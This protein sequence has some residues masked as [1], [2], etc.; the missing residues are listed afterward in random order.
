ML[1]KLRNKKTAKKV[2]IILAV[3]I[4]PAF[5]LWGSGSVLRGKDKTEAAYTG[6]VYGRL[7]PYLEY[8]DAL[9]ATRNQAVIQFGENLEQIEK[10]L[11]IESQAWERIILLAEAKKRK[12]GSTDKEVVELIEGY[13][14]FQRKGRFDNRAYQETLRYVF[15]AQARVFEEQMRQNIVL[16]KLYKQLTDGIK[17]GDE[18]LRAE[19]ERANEELSL[20]YIAALPS[21]FVK[22]VA[23]L[24]NELKDYFVNNELQFKQP[25]SFNV[26]YVSAPSR[27]EIQ[28]LLKGTASNLKETG[29]FSETSSIPGI[30][31]SPQ[32]LSLISKAKPGEYTEA[33]QIDKDYYLFRVK[34]R[35]E[36]Y[37]PEFDKIKDK[38]KEVFV[39]HKSEEI[40]KINIEDCL[41]ELHA[42]KTAADFDKLAKR[43]KLKSSSTSLF[44]YNS[45]IE[46]IGSSDAFWIKARGLKENE[47]S[48]VIALPGGFYIVKLKSSVPIDEKKF[49]QESAAFSN[50]LLAQKKQ[51]HFAAFLEGLKINSQRFH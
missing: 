47:I 35:K 15:H 42:R 36:P 41:K 3:L 6:K 24:D 44:K 51:K 20:Y 19:Y 11:N 8:R 23:A 33:V 45:Y 46:G 14:F 25:L 12:I 40:A 32:A 38:V 49:K 50:A 21:D 2:W 48:G 37:V 30:G 7:I 16:S 4:L 28:N 43:F 17:L 22:E 29:L 18:E 34:E 10:Y 9:S 1:K 5:I 27:E 13:P 31:W 39:K 26:E